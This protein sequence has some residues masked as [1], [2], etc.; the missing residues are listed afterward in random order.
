MT[1]SVDGLAGFR[2]S[3]G[4]IHCF[5]CHNTENISTAFFAASKPAFQQHR[6]GCNKDDGNSIEFVYRVLEFR[7][8]NNNISQM[9]K[10][11]EVNKSRK[12]EFGMS[13][14]GTST[15]SRQTKKHRLYFCAVFF[16]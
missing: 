8:A 2:G 1:L 9:E 11:E 14:I 5:I 16:F 15:T 10:T 6:N 13:P 4:P 12:E 3:K 7:P